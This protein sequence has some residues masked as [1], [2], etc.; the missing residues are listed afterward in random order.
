[1]YNI[2]TIIFAV[3]A[4]AALI[5]S[6]SLYFVIA[7]ISVELENYSKTN[8]ELI[9]IVKQLQNQHEP[10]PGEISDEEFEL[11]CRVVA[12]EASGEHI[13]GQMAVVQVIKSRAELW[14]M[15]LTEI[16]TAPGQFA[17]P[18]DG[19]IDD[20]TRKAVENVLVHG[21][22]IFNRPVSHFHALY[23][24]PSWADDMELARE[25]GNHRFYYAE[26]E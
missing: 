22:T 24:H 23:V 18:H 12:A 14:G 7:G 9:C 6:A 11:V 20:I 16:V 8:E 21:R 19:E 17:E 25:I 5:L 10:E 2:F 26:R 1:M 4:V 3:L 13:I 15:T